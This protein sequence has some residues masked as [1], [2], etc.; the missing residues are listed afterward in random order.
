MFRIIQYIYI[1]YRHMCM[2]LKSVFVFWM[3]SQLEEGRISTDSRSSSTDKM[4]IP[5]SE[6]FMS[7]E[8]ANRSNTVLWMVAKSESPVDRW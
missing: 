7:F 2:S 6:D 8:V 1:L 5:S 3:V 4:M